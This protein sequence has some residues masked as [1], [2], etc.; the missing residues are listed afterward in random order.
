[1]KKI[2]FL[3]LFSSLCFVFSCQKKTEKH[4]GFTETDSGLFYKLQS[5]EDSRKRPVIG[6]Y[7]ELQMV[8]KTEKDSV[9]LNTQEALYSDGA[10]FI[11][12]KSKPS[13]SGSFEEYFPEMN[14]GDSLTFLV[15][16]DSLC[17]QFLKLKT[18]PVFIHSGSLVKIET[19]LVKILT[20]DEYSKEMAHL[21]EM[22]DDMDLIEREKLQHYLKT[23]KL[24]LSPISSGIYYLPEKDG[25]GKNAEEGTSVR[26]NYKGYFMDGRLFDSTRVPFEFVLGE[27]DQVIA[28]LASG[29]SLMK[30][31]GKAKFIIPSQLAFGENGSSNKMVPPYTTVIYEVELLNVN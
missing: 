18:L 26:V 28:G 19:K 27:Q 31:G 4:V 11:P 3:L 8:Y 21:Q 23:E 16:A 29:I 22:T 15:N 5:F 30:Q 25:T 12:F 7:L 24:N 14:E 17:N 13:F 2:F 20:A 9:F 6:N 10:A 1:M